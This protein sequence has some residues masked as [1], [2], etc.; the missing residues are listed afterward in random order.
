MQDIAE[1]VSIKG[2]ILVARDGAVDRLLG[3]VGLSLREKVDTRFILVAAI[4]KGS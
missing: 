3:L 2:V 4:I 1:H